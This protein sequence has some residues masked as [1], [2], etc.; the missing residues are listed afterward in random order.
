MAS[1]AG[2]VMTLAKT[3]LL[4]DPAGAIYPDAAMYPVMDL[5]YQ[6]LQ[7]KLTRLGIPVTKEV[8][9]PII[10]A[11]GTKVLSEGAGLPIDLISPVWLGERSV[12]STLDY[13]DMTE[14]SWEPT[15]TPSTSL[16]YWTWREDQLKF[17]GSTVDR[18][19]LIKYK[20]SLGHLS[21]E[22]SVILILN[23][24][25]WL[26]HRTAMKAAA[27]IGSNPTRAQQI[28]VDL[29]IIWDDFSGT[30]IHKDQS[31]PVRRKRTRY[32]VP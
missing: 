25:N 32:R 24:D 5:A 13:I 8:S 7:T 10:V 2:Q 17:V 16:I 20:K 9:A 15:V 21:D 19:V 22:N 3:A 11:K 18:D 30:L 28:G 6:E 4:N 26:A 27:T 23:C 12:G 29:G 1:T 14:R 31:R